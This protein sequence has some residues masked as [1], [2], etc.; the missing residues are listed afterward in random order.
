MPVCQMSATNSSWKFRILSCLRSKLFSGRFDTL[1]NVPGKVITA[2]VK[3]VLICIKLITEILRD[4]S[5]G[6]RLF[7]QNVMQA[8]IQPYQKRKRTNSQK[9]QSIKNGNA[10]IRKIFLPSH[11]RRELS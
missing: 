2:F 10:L 1:V 9:R 4:L 11:N 7:F 8:W 6:S 3:D 5:T